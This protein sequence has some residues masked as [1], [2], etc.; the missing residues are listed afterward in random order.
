MRDLQSVRLVAQA[1]QPLIRPCSGCHGTMVGFGRFA[2]EVDD[3]AMLCEQCLRRRVGRPLALFQMIDLEAADL[4]GLPSLTLP[5]FL[6][7]GLS[8]AVQVVVKEPAGT[9]LPAV[10]MRWTGSGQ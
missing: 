8:T 6:P 7:G 4:A 5:V 9:V 1:D 10:L 2:I 3:G